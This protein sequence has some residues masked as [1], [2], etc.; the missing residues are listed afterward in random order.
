MQ[1]E[2]EDDDDQAQRHC[3]VP[4]RPAGASASSRP[5]SWRRL[6]PATC[7]SLVLVL[8]VSAGVAAVYSC[9][10]ARGMWHIWSTAAMRD[11]MLAGKVAVGHKKVGENAAG[12]AR[13]D[14]ACDAN[15][16][17]TRRAKDNLTAYWDIGHCGPA[18]DDNN[19]GWCG[20]HTYFPDCAETV[21][22][23]SRLCV[24]GVAAL[25]EVNASTQ[26]W[27]GARQ[28]V[29]KANCSYMYFAQYKC[30]PTTTTTTTSTTTTTTTVTNTSTTT[31]TSSTTTTTTTVET[32]DMFD[33]RLKERWPEP[34]GFSCD[35]D[36]PG[37]WRTFEAP[38]PK[39][40]ATEHN[41]LQ[42]K[43]V[44][45]EKPGLHK[46]F[47]IGDWGGV[48]G[49]NGLRPADHRRPDKFP[50]NTRP[51]I[52]GIDDS[53]QWRV[54]AAMQQRAS[55][56]K[57]DYIL[58]VGDCFYWGGIE[59]KCGEP[60]YKDIPK[61][62]WEQVFEQ[63]YHGPGI[64][65]IKWLGVLGNHDYGGYKFTA[66]W[67]QVITYTWSK[68]G[69]WM[70]PAQYWRVKVHYPGFA[71]DYFFLDSNFWDAHPPQADP[72]HN[73]CNQEHNDADDGCGPE[74][75]ANMWDC[76][77]WFQRLWN[78]Q[79][80]WFDE[81]LAKSTADWQIAVT[82]FPPLWG[83][84]FWKDMTVRH[85]IDLIVSGHAHNQELHHLKG[86]NFLSPTAWIVSGGGGGITSEAVPDPA[87]HDNQYGFVE[88]TLTK[89][90]IAIRGIS[91]GGIQI[92]ESYLVPRPPA[93]Q[94]P[95]QPPQGAQ[96]GA[97][98]KQPEAPQAPAVDAM[99]AAAEQASQSRPGPSPPSE[100]TMIVRK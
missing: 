48:L 89:G 10:P 43:D 37:C 4:A 82:H 85:G 56:A 54:A 28:L 63:V 44:C 58:N 83:L 31:T 84:D 98:A 42:L 69:R 73:L 96:A 52:G 90:E 27:Y 50:G 2:E 59:G 22:V 64:D 92:F 66:A 23:S 88:L 61:K 29:W 3:V 20:N 75:P 49:K 6:A 80:A 94:Q 15:C 97:E 33:E 71:V 77:G 14:E 32:E 7:G 81:G 38:R 62:Q 24:S 13:A 55:W 67:D 34:E 17:E 30:I 39:Q 9:G 57:P 95:A 1:E 93:P 99:P 35:R 76:P 19:M 41:G 5:S 78:A 25:V 86:D 51:F 16:Q 12:T 47:I 100:A 11:N 40:W 79:A 53:A 21:E 70:I 91:H 68:S 60:A 74:G 46:V 26:A 65:G 45:I 36:C 18:E 8:A 72:S 87:G